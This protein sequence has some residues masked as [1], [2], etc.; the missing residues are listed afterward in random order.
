MAKLKCHCELAVTYNLNDI[1]SDCLVCGTTDDHIQC[2]LQTVVYNYS[3]L[4]NCVHH[5]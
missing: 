1:L 3:V 5:Y 4:L 2:C